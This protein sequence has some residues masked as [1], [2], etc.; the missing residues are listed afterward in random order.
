MPKT[1]SY[2]SCR[3][4]KEFST[5]VLNQNNVNKEK[6]E[7]KDA[8]FNNFVLSVIKIYLHLLLLSY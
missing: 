2:G 8:L 5:N 7:K 6:M 3:C 4:L 1:M